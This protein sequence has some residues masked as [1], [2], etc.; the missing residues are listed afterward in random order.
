MAVAETTVEQKA[1]ITVYDLLHEG[2]KKRKVLSNAELQSTEFNSIA[3]SPDSKYLAAQESVLFSKMPLRNVPFNNAID[4][5][6]RTCI[7]YCSPCSEFLKISDVRIVRC[8]NSSL[9][10]S[11]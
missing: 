8:S 10:M 3:F 7:R 9:N 4:K 6:H 2:A 11:C 1:T 5:V